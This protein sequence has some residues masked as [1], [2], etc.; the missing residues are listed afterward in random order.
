MFLLSHA[1]WRVRQTKKKG[2]GVFAG[3]HISSGTVIGDY[4]GRVLSIADYDPDLEQGMYLMA[5]GD[6]MFIYP[7]MTEP[8]IYLINHSCRPNSWMYIYR[9]HTLFFALRDIFP[10]EE[11]TISYLLS[12]QDESCMNECAHSCSCGSE[13]CHGSMH[14]SPASYRLWQAHCLGEKR[15]TR[16]APYSVG[17]HLPKLSA[18]PSSIPTDP[19]YTII[20]GN[21]EAS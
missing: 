6:S 17:A 18:Y 8:G 13:F 3:R 15:K 1:Y 10:G 12:P 5:F 21:V 4:L 19:I 20:M 7:D 14:M 16:M 2:R 11:I 9:G